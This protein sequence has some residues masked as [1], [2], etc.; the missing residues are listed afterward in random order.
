MQWAFMFEDADGKDKEKFGGKGANLAEMVSLGLP[1]PPGFTITTHACREYYSLG[2]K[3]PDVLLD[4][5]KNLLNKLEEKT[6]KVFGGDANPLLVSVRS[7]AKLSM[8]GMMD[9]ILNLGLN[10]KTVRALCKVSDRRF[11]LDS[12]RRFIQIYCDVVLGI[13]TKEFDGLIEAMK[14]KLGMK[15]DYELSAENLEELIEQYKGLIAEHNAVIPEDPFEQL[16]LAIMAVFRSWN[17]PRAI[18]YRNLNR[19]PHDLGTAVN[20]QAMVFGNM[21]EDCGTGV[22]FSRNKNT[23][24]KGLFGDFLVNAQ[25]EDVV[26]GIRTPINI[27]ELAKVFPEQAEELEEIARN[28]ELHFRD[29][30]DLE[31]TI[32]TGKLYIL[33]TRNGKRSPTAQV[34][35]AV[36]MVN[37]GLLTRREALM[38]VEAEA[39]RTM[40]LPQ[41]DYSKASNEITVGV[42]ASPGAATGAI[43]FTADEAESRNS[44]GEKVILVRTETTPED[45]HGMAAAE[46]ILTSR[47]GKTSHAAVVAGGMGKPC[48]AGCVDLKIDEHARTISVNDKVFRE[49]DLITIDGT[50]GK[51]FAGKVPLIAAG[52]GDEFKEFLSWADAV[53]KIKIRTNADT[54]ADA[55]RAIELGAE[56][57]G[58]CRT[59]HMFFDEERIPFVQSMILSDT[60]DEREKYLAKLLEYQREDFKGIFKAMKGCPVTIRLLDPPLH[61][62]L[63]NDEDA[64]AKVIAKFVADLPDEKRAAREEEL[65][66]R[67]KGMHE[68]NPMLGFRGCRLGIIYPEIN[69][70]QVRAIMEAACDVE[71]EGYETRVEIMIPL[72]G[73]ISELECVEK[74]LRAVA[75]AVLEEKGRHIDYLFGTMIEVPRAALTADEIAGSAEFFS[76]GT[77]DLTQMTLGISRDDAEEKFLKEYVSMGL[78]PVNPFAEL[79]F[80]GVGK[81]IEY[82]IKEGRMTRPTLKVG[83]CGEHGG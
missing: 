69:R 62:F 8:P 9:T 73:S 59:E 27:N 17:T 60:T 14:E 83:I 64:L 26:A 29:M 51:V 49:N 70:M 5:V 30:Q 22:A 48:V 77:N 72:I 1:I 13:E 20:V 37:E 40:L 67:V 79:D 78:Y 25:G 24:E 76:F 23:G 56:G 11:V 32:E 19:I 53:R 44:A 65:R 33:Q 75:T 31:F 58:L 41:I 81:L 57:I 12:H 7:G 15:F 10:D 46:G 61:E 16:K 28:L 54:P 6:G 80:D 71:I 74:E 82:A 38:R 63:P 47:G 18:T 39:L 35:I 3:M 21:G 43:A 34:K 36:D 66:A 50:T 42:D 2:E 45:I 52:L 4:Q 55:A 68:S